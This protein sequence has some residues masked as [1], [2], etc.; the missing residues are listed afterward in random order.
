MT[1]TPS[2][3]RRS[4]TGATWATRR[5][6]GWRAC[7]SATPNARRA[8]QAAARV[9]EMLRARVR[10]QRLS[11]T[12]VTGPT[13]CFF[14]RLASHYRWQVLVRGPDPTRALR[15]LPS[16]PAWVVDIDPVDLL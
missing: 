9:A 6:R 7:S 14:T 2:T 10:D 8:E 5:S 16:D 3:P 12:T 13:P 1:T 4:A 15:G 11:A